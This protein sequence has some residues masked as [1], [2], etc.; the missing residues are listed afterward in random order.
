M[1][2]IHYEAAGA[3]TTSGFI[4]ILLGGLVITGALVWAVR[5]GIKVRGREHA[6]PRP[7]ERHPRLP[8]D[9]PVRETREYREPDEMPQA[10]DASER[11]TPHELRHSGGRRRADQAPPRWD[12][13]SSGSFGSGG[14]GGR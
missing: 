6:H 8:E 13:G 7:G 3:G 12:E 1:D 5:L 11:L 2:T 9:G 4:V 10:T 14:T